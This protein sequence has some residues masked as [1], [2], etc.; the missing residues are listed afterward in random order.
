MFDDDKC[1]IQQLLVVDQYLYE[2]IH[3]KKGG[4]HFM[5]EVATAFHVLT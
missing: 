3:M 5:Q 4:S 1:S 2:V